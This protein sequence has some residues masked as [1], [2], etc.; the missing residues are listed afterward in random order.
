MRRVYFLITQGAGI[1]KQ[2]CLAWVLGIYA[3]SSCYSRFAKFCGLLFFSPCATWQGFKTRSTKPR[4]PFL[5]TGT[6]R[7]NVLAGLL[8]TLAASRLRLGLD[9]HF[10]CLLSWFLIYF[11]LPLASPSPSSEARSS[12]FFFFEA[13]F[14]AAFA[15][16]A[17]NFALLEVPTPFEAAAASC[18]QAKYDKIETL[19]N[20]QADQLSRR[21]E[22][23]R[24]S[25]MRVQIQSNEGVAFSPPWL[26]LSGWRGSIGGGRSWRALNPREPPAGR[27]WQCT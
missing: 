16:T 4:A 19:R 5:A 27:P 20:C 21:K 25:F 18:K 6:I 12:S 7:L 8:K 14:A 26:A 23:K 24:S 13:P 15:P 3:V 11:F 9:L 2:A 17:S 1:C 22:T 10:A